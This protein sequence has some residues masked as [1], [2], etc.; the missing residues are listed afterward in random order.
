[1]FCF[2]TLT[3]IDNQHDSLRYIQTSIVKSLS[4][5]WILECWTNV[6]MW[7]Q[8]N[9]DPTPPIWLL[10][11]SVGSALGLEICHQNRRSK[12]IQNLK[13][14]F[15]S[16]EHSFC[17]SSKHTEILFLC[18][19]NILPGFSSPD[20]TWSLIPPFISQA[21]SVFQL[22]FL[23]HLCIRS[24]FQMWSLGQEVSRQSD[25]LFIPL[26]TLHVPFCRFQALLM[27]LPVSHIDGVLLAGSNHSLS[28]SSRH[29]NFLPAA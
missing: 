24:F 23:A 7:H 8:C 25:F 14:P 11:L 19:F 29:S 2:L 12:N 4:F 20:P 9:A 5:R 15:A 28:F 10:L 26:T 3:P 13:T 18:W 16:E 22:I 27:P 17:V 1:M 21:K 6:V